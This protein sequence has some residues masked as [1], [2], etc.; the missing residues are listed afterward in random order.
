[1]WIAI[2]EKF[3]WDTQ[4]RSNG[5]VRHKHK[6]VIVYIYYVTLLRGVS[7]NFNTDEKKQ[8]YTNIFQLEIRCSKIVIREIAWES[9]PL[10]D[11]NSFRLVLIISRISKDTS[12]IN[13]KKKQ[14]NQLNYKRNKRNKKVMY[15]YNHGGNKKTYKRRRENYCLL[16]KVFLQTRVLISRAKNTFPFLERSSFHRRTLVHLLSNYP[17]FYIYI[18]IYVKN[19]GIKETGCNK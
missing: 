4:S 2:G 6:R 11:L 3:A 8:A 7:L 17:R 16:D 13:K 12:N 15:S 1:M 10:F 14:N 18:Y 9:N 5:Y 19:Y